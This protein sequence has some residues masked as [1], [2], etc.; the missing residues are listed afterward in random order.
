MCYDDGHPGVSSFAE[1]L[2]AAEERLG[3]AREAIRQARSASKDRYRRGRR[4]LGDLRVGDQ[5]YVRLRD[6]PVPGVP[7]GKLAPTKLGPWD[8][9]EV[10]SPHRVRLR[11][12]ADLGIGDEFSVEQIDLL[13]RSPDPFE[14]SRASEDHS[15]LAESVSPSAPVADGSVLGPTHLNDDA[16][17]LPARRRLPPSALREFD[18]GTLD[19]P[20]PS[21]LDD[22]MRGP[23][24]SKRVL[25]VDGVS[26]E[27]RERPVAFLSRLTSPGEQR[28]VAA[29]L[30]L[31]C[32]AWAFAKWAHLLEGAEVTVVTD[33]APLG[34]MLTS[35][36]AVPYG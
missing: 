11:V 20:L 13:P 26:H 31:S 34:P 8:I 10:L 2:A 35:T 32:L 14:H 16:A 3:E 17:P 33:H 7:S 5:A 23:I 36:S 6:R 15:D 19:A 24:F 12:P 25:M 18:L 4:P 28:M 27:L 30:E 9:V 1:R 21:V 22:A 29:E